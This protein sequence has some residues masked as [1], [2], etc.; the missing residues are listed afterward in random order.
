MPTILSFI[1][2]NASFFLV[3]VLYSFNGIFIEIIQLLFNCF[4]CFHKI[5]FVDVVVLALIVLS[6]L[7]FR[8]ELKDKENEENAY[9]RARYYIIK[10]RS[11]GKSEI[12]NIFI[13]AGWSRDT[14]EKIFKR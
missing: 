14:L 12:M 8:N 4:H 10:M 13:R 7:K 3:K 5:Y 6:I 11:E 1:G 2:L 9:S